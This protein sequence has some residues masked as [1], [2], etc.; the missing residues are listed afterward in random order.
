[1]GESFWLNKQ[2]QL[3]CLLLGSSVSLLNVSP[4]AVSGEFKSLNSAQQS[5][6]TKGRPL[7]N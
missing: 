7:I 2:A 3:A 1:M 6:K 4:T 5:P